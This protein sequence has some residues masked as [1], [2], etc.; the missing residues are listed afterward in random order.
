LALATVERAGR[1][2]AAAY[3][4]DF[5]KMGLAAEGDE[6]REVRPQPA[7]AGRRRLLGADDLEL[8]TG[9]M[10]AFFAESGAGEGARPGWAR[11][12][13][14]IHVGRGSLYFWLDP[15]PVCMAGGRETGEGLARIGPVYTPP[16]YR[17]RGYAG[18]LVANLSLRRLDG[19]C[20][21][22]CLFTDVRNATSN[23]LYAAGGYQPV[24]GVNEVWFR[25]V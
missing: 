24:A 8:A 5:P 1:I 22:C 13:A 15:D 4:S 25:R 6:L 2:V 21:T 7:V 10:A 3:R 20:H 23:H 19:G 14:A 9:W 17:R 11:E 12:A 18:A 16:A